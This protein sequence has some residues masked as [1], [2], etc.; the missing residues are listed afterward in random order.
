[1]HLVSE[2]AGIRAAVDENIL[3]GDVAGLR[4]AQERAGRAKF[5]GAAEPPRRI[6]GPGSWMS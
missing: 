6:A 1:M 4:R 5:L 2:R 3:A